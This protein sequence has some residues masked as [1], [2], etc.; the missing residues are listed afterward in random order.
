[1]RRKAVIG[2][3]MLVVLHSLAAAQPHPI[4][5]DFTAFRDGNTVL[6]KWTITS[7][8]TCNGIRIYRA[9]DTINYIQVGDIAGVCG[10][11][12][13]PVPYSFTDLSPIPNRINYYR[14]EL[15]TQGFS[16]YVSIDFIVL[17]ESGYL[18]RPQPITD[19]AVIY[20]DN[21][22]NDSHSFKL[23]DEKGELV[24]TIENITSNTIPFNRAGLSSGTYIFTIESGEKIKVK[25]KIVVL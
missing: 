8:S 23:Y 19:N 2:L 10:S 13:S 9:E 25:G 5:D 1:M 17:G 6:L 4:L 21:P 14:L 12:T 11:S 3:F 16:K 15:G 22:S 24:R 18:I 20:F 7:G